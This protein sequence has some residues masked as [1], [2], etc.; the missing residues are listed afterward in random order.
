MLGGAGRHALAEFSRSPIRSRSNDDRILY[1]KPS[2]T[3]ETPSSYTRTEGS[4]ARFDPVVEPKPKRWCRAPG[5]AV[6]MLCARK[7]G[8]VS[9]VVTAPVMLAEANRLNAR[10]A[11]LPICWRS[12]GVD[13]RRLSLETPLGQNVFITCCCPAAATGGA[14]YNWS[15]QTLVRITC[16]P[17][18]MPQSELLALNASGMRACLSKTYRR[19]R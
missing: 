7:S 10:P 18:P 14:F 11:R 12:D 5:A 17:S 4:Y 3:P 8:V 19:N 15:I 6:R 2:L 9:F 16:L 13:Q 1:E